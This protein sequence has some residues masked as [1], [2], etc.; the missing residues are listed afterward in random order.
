MAMHSADVAYSGWELS[1]INCLHT[2]NHQYLLLY[3]VSIDGFQLVFEVLSL[4]RIYRAL[5]TFNQ[6]HLAWTYRFAQHDFSTC[7]VKERGDGQ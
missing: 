3:F 4:A 1:M 2:S 6:N 7:I 5:A